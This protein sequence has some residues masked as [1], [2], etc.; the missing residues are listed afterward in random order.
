[1]ARALAATFCLVC[2]VVVVAELPAR[3]AIHRFVIHRVELKWL[4]LADLVVALDQAVERK[5]LH[6]AVPVAAQHQAV[7]QKSLHAI[8]AVQLQAVALKAPA[9]DHAV[10]SFRPSKLSLRGLKGKLACHAPSCGVEACDPCGSAPTCGVEIASCG[11]GCAAPSCGPTCG[12][13]ISACDPCAAPSCDSGCGLKIG[14]RGLLAK[15]FKCKSSCD[16]VRAVIR[17][18][19]VAAPVDRL[20][21]PVAAAVVVVQYRLQQPLLLLHLLQSL[22]HM[23][24]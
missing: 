23:H 2:S 9:V 11:S 3:A 1:M 13:E 24:T 19:L 17:H 14:K 16:T 18:Q 8:H 21:Q 7:E 15:I 6:H 12:A 10:Q 22:T 20:Q 5:S 4:H